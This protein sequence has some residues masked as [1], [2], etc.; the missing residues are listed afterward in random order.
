[1]PIK[2]TRQINIDKKLL[3]NRSG[4]TFI[5]CVSQTEFKTDKELKEVS[6]SSSLYSKSIERIRDEGFVW[7][8]IKF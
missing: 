5:Y 7:F 8:I 3:H 4:K 2:V 6:M 1:M